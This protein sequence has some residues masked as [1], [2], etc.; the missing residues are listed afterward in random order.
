MR[1]IKNYNWTIPKNQTKEHYLLKNIAMV[2]LRE[3]NI[4]YIGTEIYIKGTN[5]NI[6]NKKIIDCVGIDKNKRYTYGIEAKVSRSDFL[7]GYCARCNYT[8][9]IC[10]DG[11]IDK[12]ELPKHIGLIY[13]DI[14]NFRFVTNAKDKR[15]IGIKLIKKA[16]YNLDELFKDKNGNIIQYKYDEHINHT[17][18]AIIRKNLNELIYNTDRIPKAKVIKGIRRF[19]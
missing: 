16:Y 4:E 13:V 6:S 9:I 8:Y 7:N 5:T 2:Y 12:N 3:R 17:I 14:P 11:L 19:R 1:T 15:L 10:P 18:N